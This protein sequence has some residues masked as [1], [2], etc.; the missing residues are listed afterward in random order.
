MGFETTGLA[1][2]IADLVDM[3][4]RVGRVDLADM[5]AEAG[6]S[7]ICSEFWLGDLD[8]PSTYFQEVA[9]QLEH[10]KFFVGMGIDYKIERDNKVGYNNVDWD[11]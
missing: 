4:D 1:N 10:S 3:A 5:V 8:T 2:S 7:N 6:Y 11:N 9:V